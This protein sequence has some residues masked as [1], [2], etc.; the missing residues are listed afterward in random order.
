MA[1]KKETVLFEI[2]IDVDSATTELTKWNQIIQQANADKKAALQLYKEEI[3]SKKELTSLFES[4]NKQIERGKLAVDMYNQAIG[5]QKEKIEALKD[6]V[7]NLSMQ[8]NALSNEQQQ[9]EQGQQ[10]Q[11]MIT[12]MQAGLDA[13]MV[14][15]QEFQALVDSYQ[16]S[17]TTAAVGN[18]GFAKT[19]VNMYQQ[20]GS[21][22]G[23]FTEIKTKFSA[24]SKAVIANPIMA[25]IAAIVVI[26]NAL[27]SAIENNQAASQKLDA[28]MKPLGAVFK[29]LEKIIGEL[30]M[31]LLKGIEGFEGIATAAMK[32]CEKLPFVGQY[33][34]E[35][36]AEIEKSIELEKA[37]KALSDL[38]K[39]T[40]VKN[41]ENALAAAKLRKEAGD[42]E[43]KTA[44]ERIAANKKANQLELES[45]IAAKRIADEKLKIALKEAEGQTLTQEKE[46]E[47]AKFRA[48]AINAELAHFNMLGKIENQEKSFVKDIK[49]EST[50]TSSGGGGADK[51]KERRD[52][53]RELVR[54][55]ED[56]ITS[57][58]T[59]EQKKREAEINLSYNRQKEDLQRKLK[60]E[61]NLTVNAKKAINDTIKSLEEQKNNELKALDQNEFEKQKEIVE[62]KLSLY[63]EDSKEALA[64][65][66]EKLELERKEEIAAAERLN[67]D[68]NL[69]N[70]KYDEAIQNEKDTAQKA[71]NEE[72]LAKFTE[73]WSAE[74]AQIDSKNAKE[75]EKA[76]EKN[77]SLLTIEKNT[78]AQ[79]LVLKQEE[80]EALSNLEDINDQQLLE[81]KRILNDE[82]AK[83][84][85]SLSKKDKDITEDVNNK[86]KASYQALYDSIYDF[87]EEF[88]ENSEA[89]AVFSKAFAL[90][91]IGLDTASALTSGIA[92]SQKATTF[93]ANLIAMATTV[94]AILTN[95]TKAKKT[96]SS[97]KPPKIKFASGGY[98]SGSGSGTSDSIPALLSNGESVLTASATS[99]FSP[100]LSAFNQLGGGIP[101]STS[102]V[103]SQVM[104]EEMLSRAFAKAVQQMPNPVVS[105]EEINNTNSR[106]QVLETYRSL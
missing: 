18:E 78:L 83:L 95:I 47:L 23:V 104:G 94:A 38:E 56:A 84:N 71:L 62:K 40:Q 46:A 26:F 25:I 15:Q 87:M 73:K 86:K 81:K 7:N 51:A 103:S 77:E 57:L 66:I 14:K 80:L 9:G 50:K 34:K 67:I 74:Q 19:L 41:A 17:I 85:D 90:Y 100:M 35:A 43:N 49:G 102:H 55:A 44:K 91:Q 58:I 4:S 28:I 92:A 99:M 72:A 13:A 8:Y 45:Y 63:K 61:N 5:I 105:V 20:S 24:F 3:I 39:D 54:Q 11:A 106:V 89:M 52:K 64:L 16:E 21:L 48:D 97:E 27:K 68:K 31:W 98:V 2:S 65:R 79:K 82:I 76:Q 70:K 37:K 33:F 59:D 1:T 75:I 22:G 30:L 88:A 32:A 29:V 93:P 36:N 42:K 10:L 101:I 96:L 69:V 6:A 60:E 53:E 12:N